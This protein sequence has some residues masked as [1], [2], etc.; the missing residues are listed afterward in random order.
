MAHMEENGVKKK[1]IN[2]KLNAFWMPDSAYVALA[3]HPFL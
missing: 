1:N 3:F 2:L